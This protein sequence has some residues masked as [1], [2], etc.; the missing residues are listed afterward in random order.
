MVLDRARAGGDIGAPG[1]DPRTWHGGTRA[2]RTGVWRA[3][4]RHRPWH[5]VLDP[6]CAVDMGTCGRRCARYRHARYWIAAGQSE[7][8][9]VEL[10]LVAVAGVTALDVVCGASLARHSLARHSSPKLRRRRP[11]IDYHRRTG[12]PKPPEQMRER[13]ETL[14]FPA[15]CARR[16]RCCL[17]RPIPD[18]GVTSGGVLPEAYRSRCS[19]SR[20]FLPPTSFARFWHALLLSNCS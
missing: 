17:F 8:E 10:A 11:A 5:F 4:D 19:R 2:D 3:G 1:F 7:K 14:R 12:F 13:H 15:T 20:A 18:H 9:Y 6:S 16:K